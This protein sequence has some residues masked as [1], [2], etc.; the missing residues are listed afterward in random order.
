MARRQGRELA[1]RTL[2]QA[3]RSGSPVLETWQSVKED[4]TETIDKDEDDTLELDAD[5]VALADKLITTYSDNQEAVDTRLQGSIE[6][7]TFSQM[8]QTDLNVLRLAMTELLYDDN[9][10]EKVTLEMAVRLAKKYGGEESG[11]FVNGVLGRFVRSQ[12]VKD[13]VE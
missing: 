4:L 11:K 12:G 2:F 10:P 6:G 7:W 1:F 3:G 9:V 8:A 13:V 5:A